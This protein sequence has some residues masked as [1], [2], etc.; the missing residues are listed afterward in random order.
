TGRPRTRGN[1][2]TADARPVRALR[3]SIR[4]GRSSRFQPLGKPRASVKR[5]LAKILFQPQQLI[6][7]GHTVST[8]GRSGFDLTVGHRDGEVGD[9]RI[10][11]FA[12]AVADHAAVTAALSEPH[13]VDRFGKR[14]DLVDLYEN[15]VRD[16]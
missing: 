15:A 11:G 16:M 10:L 8:G 4:R 5:V 14:A 13:G 3:S 2:S 7:L 6:V 9:E 12:T 1:R